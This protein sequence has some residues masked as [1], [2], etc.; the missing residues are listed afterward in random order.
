MKD[1]APIIIL[2]LLG[3]AYLGYEQFL[4]GGGDSEE[5]QVRASFQSMAKAIA[6]NN[7]KQSETMVAPSFV[8]DDISKKEFLKILN[9]KRTIYNVS[10]VKIKASGKFASISYKR[11]EA[12]EGGEPF[13]TNVKAERWE[14]MKGPVG[15]KLQRLGTGDRWSAGSSGMADKDVDVKPVD[16][17]ELQS[18]SEARQEVIA[19]Y[20]SSG[21]RY[22]SRNKRDPFWS[23][24]AGSSE[25]G[26][27]AEIC[28]QDRPR[29]QLEKYD[30]LSLRL[31]GVISKDEE[32]VA[33]IESPGGSGHT[34]RM[35]DY[36]GHN[37]GKVVGIRS[38][39]IVVSEKIQNLK[40]KGVFHTVE[41]SLRLRPK[42]E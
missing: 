1:K 16:E 21:E 10:D 28:E 15:W 30:L 17:D 38:D 39:K 6:T 11:T 36:L 25:E 35:S 26:E 33:L 22:T 42:E 23:L 12:R 14:K 34:V 7:H 4:K 27:E 37:C 24:M 40:E 18:L 2:L 20:M 19:S 32:L 8:D 41:T 3:L 5:T 13:I 29:E 9:Y 31:A